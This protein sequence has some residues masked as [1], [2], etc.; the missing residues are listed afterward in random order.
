[1][2]MKYKYRKQFTYNGETFRIYAN[3]LDELIAKK[4]KKEKEIDEGNKLSTGN[5]K[6]REWA[7]YALQTYKPSISAE[8]RY[9]IEHRQTKH[10]FPEI[11]NL[12][13]ADVKPF[14]CQKVLNNQDGMS[15]SHIT[16]LH[17][18]LCFIFD[19]AVINKL[20]KES[21]AEHLVRP[22]GTC[23]QRR[24]I[25][26]I[27]REHLLKVCNEDDRLVFFLFMLQCGCR[28]KEVCNLKWED[29]IKKDDYYLLHIRG[30]KTINSDRFVPLP[31]ELWQRVEKLENGQYIFTNTHGGQHTKDSYRALVKKLKRQMNI[32]M[33]CVV[34]RNAL[35]EPLPLA[36]DFIPYF[37]RHT[38][39]TDLQKKGIDVR[40][41]QKLMGHA[42]I[43]T[44]AN[45]YTHQDDE[46]LALAAELLGA[47]NNHQ[48]NH[49]AQKN[50]Q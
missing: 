12:R 27:E 37:L 38:Y 13:I 34:V 26:P 11:G 48:N 15:K 25:T 24:S 36:E 8:H 22:K 43:S 33:G 50:G 18:E 7:E 44:T 46:T 39:C 9:A 35:V 23:K 10:I 31:I 32:S 49:S 45:I 28:S 6:V 21:P 41:A 3:T 14:Q 42:D 29:I 2:T 30:T 4:L 40:I 1:M 17:Q 47:K 19:T 20:I 16:Q 5:M